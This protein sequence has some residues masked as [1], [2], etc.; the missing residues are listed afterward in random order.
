MIKNN[1]INMIINTTEGK[2]AINDSYAIRREA[3]NKK[4][5]YTTTI[6]GGEAICAALH[7]QAQIGA[8]ISVYRLQQLHEGIA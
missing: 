4:I 2:S 7:S 6:A 3:L 8:G 5:T 1:E